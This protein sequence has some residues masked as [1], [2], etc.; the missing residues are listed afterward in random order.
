MNADSAFICG[1]FVPG[2]RMP[3][4]IGVFDCQRAVQV[5]TCAFDL[6]CSHRCQVPGSAAGW[7]WAGK[8]FDRGQLGGLLKS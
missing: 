3:I 4:M 1:L 7:A 2:C 5:L 6:N 8:L